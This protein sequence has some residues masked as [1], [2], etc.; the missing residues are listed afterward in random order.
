MPK[1]RRMITTASRV[2][3]SQQIQDAWRQGLHLRMPWCKTSLTLKGSTRLPTRGIQERESPCI[4]SQ[5]SLFPSPIRP[6]RW[7]TATSPG[8]RFKRNS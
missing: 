5:H 3:N 6:S 8:D 7:N 2:H 1:Q 4:P